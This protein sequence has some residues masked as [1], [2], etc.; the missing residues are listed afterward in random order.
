MKKFIA[1]LLA[2]MMLL[3]L[4]ACG[5]NT[6][7][8]KAA[9]HSGADKT[10]TEK[11][12][13]K[14]L[15]PS[16]ASWPVRE[17]WKVFEYMQEG[18]GA[19]L[20]IMVVPMGDVA[21]KL[22]LMISDPNEM[23]DL[24]AGDNNKSYNQYWGEG[25]AALDDF[26]EYMPNYNAWLDSLSDDEYYVAV[27]NRKAADGK[28]YYTP[29]TGREG[30]TRMRAWLYREDIFKKHNLKVPETF[31]ELYKVCKKLKT[32]YPDSYPFSTRSISY[33]FD[34]LGSSFDKW[35]EHGLYY[36]FDDGEW[37]WGATEDTAKEVLEFYKRMVKEGLMPADAISLEV[38]KWNEYVLTDRTFIMPHLQLYIDY[39]N[40]RAQENNPEFKIVAMKPPVANE[41]T[42][43]PLMDRGDIEQIGTVIGD[44]GDQE[45]MI[46]AAKFIDW[47]YTDEAVELVSWGK[48][49]ET[50]EW[51][52]EEKGERRYITNENNDQANT[53]YGF[54]LYGTFI[55]LDPTAA[56]AL[57]S[58]TTLE[59]EDI[60]IDSA[61]PY[62][63][64][65]MWVA[66][67]E[68]EQAVIDEKYVAVLAYTEEMMTKF[69]LDQEPMSKYDSFV[70]ELKKM[71]VDEILAAYTSAY[72]RVK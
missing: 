62:H 21:T 13:L 24:L 11:T 51:V 19:T 20:D 38:T 55:K 69:M 52:D 8:D 9:D 18:S 27:T 32:I 26:A 43:V 34:I 28:I 5:G 53:M 37:R 58:E 64:P 1:F 31:D 50:F 57:Q 71:G 65:G 29:G 36:D 41:D 67:N 39:F 70:K 45:R 49:G 56:K 66:L 14:Y 63:N 33:L 59:C 47:M 6:E 42:G 23:P 10:F 46:N 61:L 22:P 2:A 7:M 16:H 15:V 68:E 17:D 72:D 60:V 54:Q 25:I 30:R 4:C 35:W 48:E 40:S 12:V 3:A 44:T